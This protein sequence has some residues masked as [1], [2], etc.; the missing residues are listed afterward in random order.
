MNDSGRRSALRRRGPSATAVIGVVLVVLT[1]GALTLV[2]PHEDAPAAVP[3]QERVLRTAAL[4]CP[5]APADGGTLRVVATGA[6]GS[7][8][9][10]VG[11]GEEARTVELTPR[12]VRAVEGVAEAAVVS[13][14]GPLA[15]DLVAARFGDRSPA[16]T[17]CSAP[18]PVTWFTGVGAG[19]R[20]DSVLELVNPDDGLAV[21]DVYVRG[22]GGLVDV[23]DLRGVTVPGHES[24]RFD[25]AEVA[26]SRGE[27]SLEVVVS[28]GRLASSVLD[29]I[30]SIG[31]A[32]E[33]EDWLSGQPEPVEEAVL[34]GLVPGKGTHVLSVANPGEDEARVTIRILTADSAFVPRGL[35]ELRVPAG[36]VRTQTLTSVVRQA[37]QDGALGYEVTSTEPVTAS[38]RS[39]VAADLSQAA[40]V[41]PSGSAMTAVL[42]S[43]RGRL[44]LAGATGVGV[45]EVKAWTAAGR[46]LK[47]QRVEVRPGQGGV[48]D[49][50]EQA[51][52]VEVSPERTSVHAAAVVTGRGATVVPFRERLDRTLV[53]DVRPG[54]P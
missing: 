31:S 52:L 33:T 37:I 35:E 10:R 16:A 46:A 38:A 8:V 26:P 30:P 50:P 5:S 29:R 4:G 22:R 19:A 23:S 15:P 9:V 40:P 20:H 42:P 43:G 17:E 6:A 3:P 14:E 41:L 21:A 54:L 2:R 25:L 47:A 34:L 24:L 53:P 48:V 28:R 13:A 49:L 12:R 1:V 18:Q 39:V 27:L 44:V 32:P 36:A 45:V 51:A 7:G 11:A